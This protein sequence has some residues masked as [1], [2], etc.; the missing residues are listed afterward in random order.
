VLGAL[1]WAPQWYDP[2]RGP[3]DDVAEAAQ[4]FVV[5]ALTRGV[6][7]DLRDAVTAQ[8]PAGLDAR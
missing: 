2:D 8:A 6:P 1:N 4:R 5:H 7:E 3:V